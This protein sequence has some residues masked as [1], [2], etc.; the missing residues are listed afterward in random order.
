MLH[1]VGGVT[2]TDTS[3]YLITSCD[4]MSVTKF[5]IFTTM[6]RLILLNVRV[7]DLLM[8]NTSEI[9]FNCSPRPLNLGL[10]SWKCSDRNFKY[11]IVPSQLLGPI[12]FCW[13]TKNVCLRVQLPTAAKMLF[14]PCTCNCITTFFH[15]EGRFEA[16]KEVQP[17]NVL[18]KCQVKWSSIN[19]Y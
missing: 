5:K 1:V 14:C 3:W 9:K 13:A 4:N 16:I 12:N 2:I 6:L 8:E 11:L 15:K 7:G 17:C 10:G 19:V 18:F